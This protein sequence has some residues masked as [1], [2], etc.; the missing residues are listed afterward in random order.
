[1]RI[2]VHADGR[3]RRRAALAR[4]RRAA[5]C[6][7]MPRSCSA[8]RPGRTPIALYRALGRLHRAGS[9]DFRR[10]TTF[11]LDEFAGLPAATRAAIAR[12]CSS[13]SSARQPAG[14]AATHSRT[15]MARD[16]AR[17]V[18][19]Y[20]RAIAAAGGIDLVI[21]GIGAT[22]TSASTSRPRRSTRART[23]RVSRAAHA[24]RQRVRSSADDCD[25]V[26][27]DALSMGMGTILSARESC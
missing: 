16:L 21:L 5:R 13:T 15:A 3:R 11:N 6:A 12:S 27:R 10:A 1:M 20:E 17:E 25:D 19:R 18:A 22:A 14:R 8:C 2:V 7:T 9:A 4:L 24:P 23:A 26:P